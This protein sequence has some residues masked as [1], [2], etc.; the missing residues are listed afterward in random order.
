MK[1]EDFAKSLIS[2]VE[3]RRVNTYLKAADKMVKKI[4]LKNQKSK[5]NLTLQDY[6]AF[7]EFVIDD[8][9]EFEEKIKDYGVIGK[10][11]YH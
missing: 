8:L 1:A 5:G 10:K 9:E 7:K 6:M 4:F 3:P 2:Y 11:K